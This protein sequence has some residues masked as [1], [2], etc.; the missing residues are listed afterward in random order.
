MARKDIFAEIS[1]HPKRERDRGYNPT[2]AAKAMIGS[3]EEL[4][5]LA[6]RGTILELDPEVVDPSPF[7]D[8]LPDDDPQPFEDFKKSIAEDGQKVPAQVRA[9]P[10]IPGRY[11]VVY[12]HRRQRAA[13]ELGIKLKALLIDISDH[14]LAVVQGIENAARQDL[15]WIERALFA[16]R[17]EDAGVKSRDVQAALSV[18]RQELARLR[19]VVAV[20]PVDLIEQIGRAPRVGR[21]RWQELA[22][23]IELFPER[24]VEAREMVSAGTISSDQRF[25]SLLG[26]MKAG[27]TKPIEEAATI[28]FK[29]VASNPRG[30]AFAKFI[31]SRLPALMEE[32]EK[33]E[34]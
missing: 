28:D 24:L 30:R 11:Q 25:Q 5:E 6:A 1:N 19:G 13:K 23:Q 27:P 17:M 9:H 34:T 10:T 22:K 14:E 2:G 29:I 32:F 4:A 8:R 21:P 20:I 3:L 7:P 16:K 15:S 31:E 26:R 33:G 18:D 12:G